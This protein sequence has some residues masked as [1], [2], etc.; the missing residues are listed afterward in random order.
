MEI[1][2]V[3]TFSATRAKSES[4]PAANG[5]NFCKSTPGSPRALATSAALADG[6]VSRISVKI[7]VAGVITVDPAGA[8]SLTPD[9]DSPVKVSMVCASERDTK[10]ALG[11]AEMRLKLPSAAVR[12]EG[13]PGVNS[14]SLL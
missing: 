11:C 8:L 14:P 1:I 4:T 7:V 13:S 12:V 10:F 5:L 9:T 3:A 2:W 6:F